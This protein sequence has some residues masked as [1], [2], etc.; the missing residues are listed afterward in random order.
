MGGGQRI[1]LWQAA[2]SWLLERPAI[3]RSPWLG[4]RA[5]VEEVLIELYLLGERPTPEETRVYAESLGASSAWARE[6]AKL[7]RQRLKDPMR[8][9]KELRR[10]TQWRHT[11]L[12]P[13]EAAA[14]HGLTPVGERLVEALRAAAADFLEQAERDPGAKS[15]ALAWELVEAL[16]SALRIWAE[17]RDAVEDVSWPSSIPSRRRARIVPFTSWRTKTGKAASEERLK[18]LRAEWEKETE[19]MGSEWFEGSEGTENQTEPT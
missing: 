16:S 11:F 8:Q 1:E 3:T 6:V 2:L 7:W 12:V 14:E 18:A 10:S 5:R 17:T 4:D 13:E 15:T 19:R 9:P